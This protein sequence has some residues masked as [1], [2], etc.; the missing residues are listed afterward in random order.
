MSGV[1]SSKPD[2]QHLWWI[3]STWNLYL[4]RTSE[5]SIER[6]DFN[7]SLSDKSTIRKPMCHLG[8]TYKRYF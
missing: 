2:S 8:K 6:F 5:G 3:N 1:L 4:T 7:T